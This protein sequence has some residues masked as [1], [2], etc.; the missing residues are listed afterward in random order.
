MPLPGGGQTALRLARFMDLGRQNLGLARLAEAHWDAV[1]ILA[2]AGKSPKKDAV[3]G[4]W[5]SEIPGHG[6]TL[7]PANGFFTVSGTK[8]FCSGAGMVDCALVTV[9]KPEPLLVEIDFRTVGDWVQYD[10]SGWKTA[11]FLETHTATSTFSSVPLC[12]K[13]IIGEPGWYVN[14]IGFWRGA[15]G[16]AA[17]WA[18]GAEALVDYALSQSR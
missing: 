10:E 11:A 17:C 5:A 18:G 1:A 15:C 9:S 12:A 2:E 7:T 8:R 16:P 4:V 14:R 13:Q 3:Y 6:L